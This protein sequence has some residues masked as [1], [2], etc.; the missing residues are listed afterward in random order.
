MVE[1]PK[2]VWTRPLE[3][4]QSF[5][6]VHKGKIESS[7]L[8][9]EEGVPWYYDIMKFLEMGV[10]PDS[11]NKRNRHLVRMMAMKYILCEGKLYRRS[12]DGIHLR[13]L[14]KE[15]A[16]RVIEEVHQ[17]ICGPHMYR[18]MLAKNILRMGYYWNTMETDYV[19]FVK[20]CHDYQTHANLNH[21]LPSKLY[22]ITSHCLS[23]SGA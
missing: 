17:R 1:I 5:E 6:L 3:I 16:K 23:Q 14:K 19:D 22:N 11:A 12:Y 18:R 13:Y 4:R 8:V 21:M 9:I 15:E 7:I 20:S 10:Y 2:G